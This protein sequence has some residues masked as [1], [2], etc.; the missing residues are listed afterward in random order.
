M[1]NLKHL[2]ISDPR[3]REKLMQADQRP[4][5]LL[6][7]TNYCNF[8]CTY[9]ATGRMKNR[10]VNADLGFVKDVIDQ[11]TEYDWP[12]SFGQTYEPFLHP[13]IDEI[14]AYTH[15]KNRRF[16]SPTNGTALA[17][18]VR[19]LP[20]DLMISYSAD[21]GDF[22]Y[23]GAAMDFKKY[24]SG[25]LGFAKYRMKGS[26]PGVISFQIADYSI[27]ESRTLVYD[28]AIEQV[29]AM[30]EK[31]LDLARALGIVD[32]GHDPDIWKRRIAARRP[33]VLHNENGTVIRAVFT[34]II[35]NTYETFLEPG[36]P[37]VRG[38]CDSCFLMM[39]IQ[40]DRSVAYC[41]C[42]PT[43]KAV[44]GR[45]G[46]RETIKDFWNGEKMKK[47]RTAFQDFNPPAEFC[48]HCLSPVSE[49]IKPLLTVKAP[50][51][52]AD[53]LSGIG[54]QENL[55]WFQFPGRSGCSF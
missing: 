28:K 8:S 51:T 2:L 33:I 4:D 7:P 39:S 42:D 38:Y 40:A 44:A 16:S 52:V 41:C 6:A 1:E 47:V 36:N 3:Y 53:I 37:R 14:V 20:M 32:E 5:V 46:T 35:Q 25:L 13:R 31:T 50:E 30:Y 23:R 10:H 29:E 22:A 55:S 54:V 9:C 27:L 15:S 43:A 19:D 26:V 45:I 18:K 48:H 21:E 34:K 17:P 24:R 49:H 12:L 11:A